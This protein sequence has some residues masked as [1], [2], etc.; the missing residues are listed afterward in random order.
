MLANRQAEG[1]HRCLVTFFLGEFLGE[2]FTPVS[3]DMILVNSGHCTCGAGEGD[4]LGPGE[5]NV[6]YLMCIEH[7]QCA[8]L[9]VEF[10]F[11][12]LFAT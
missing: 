1:N 4:F 3:S 7:E 10:V 2:I 11:V 6:C 12:F 8:Q 9:P 5:N